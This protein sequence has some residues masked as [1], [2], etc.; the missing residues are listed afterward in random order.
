M[1]GLHLTALTAVNEA[2]FKWSSEV[3]LPIRNGIALAYQLVEFLTN[4]MIHAS[5]QRE[6]FPTGGGASSTWVQL[7]NMG[8][9]YLTASR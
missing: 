4:N 3:R 2:F 7:Y 8:W 9:L 6:Y 5:I 1:F